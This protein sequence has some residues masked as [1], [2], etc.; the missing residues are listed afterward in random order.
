MYVNITYIESE[1]D[2]YPGEATTEA[3]D[4]ELYRG[5]QPGDREAR[6]KGNRVSRSSLRQI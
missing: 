2:E 4:E 3:S 6:V 5:P 1:S